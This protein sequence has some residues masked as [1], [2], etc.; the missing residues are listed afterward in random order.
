MCGL[1]GAGKSTYARRLEERGWLRFSIDREAWGMGLVDV[2][3]PPD[4]S[5]DIRARQR[6]EIADALRAGRDVVVDYSFWSRAQRDEYRELGRECGAVVDVVHLDVPEEELRRR[7]AERRGRHPDDYPVA[8]LL[9]GYLSGFEAP[10]PDETDVTVVPFR[11][12]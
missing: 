8:D 11:D 4:A 12:R 5:D 9:A 6:R 2:P 1:A 10:G 3:F 7:L